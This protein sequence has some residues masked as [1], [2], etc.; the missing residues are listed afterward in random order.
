MTRGRRSLQ[1]E[2][3]N[4]EGAEELTRRDGK[5]RRGRRAAYMRDLRQAK[6][7]G[8]MSRGQRS[9][10]QATRRDE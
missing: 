10:K 5:M 7:D 4:D 9:R 8:E 1:A 6:R 2:I 3:A